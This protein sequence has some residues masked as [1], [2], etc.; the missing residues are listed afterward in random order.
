M[1]ESTWSELWKAEPHRIKFYD[2]YDVLKKKRRAADSRS[3]DAINSPAVFIR[4]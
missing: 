3:S 2:V 1:V 4:V